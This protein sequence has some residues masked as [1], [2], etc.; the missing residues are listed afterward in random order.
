[1]PLP[2]LHLHS[3]TSPRCPAPTFALPP[4]SQVGLVMAAQGEA[5]LAPGRLHGLLMHAVAEQGAMLVAARAEMQERVGAHGWADGERSA[6]HVVRTLGMGRGYG[7]GLHSMSWTVHVG[8]AGCSHA[9]RQAAGK[10]RMHARF[11]TH[12]R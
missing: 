9:G 3:A 5:V 6:L 1:M 11:Q 7:F 10:Q 12:R 8:S 4:V 2:L